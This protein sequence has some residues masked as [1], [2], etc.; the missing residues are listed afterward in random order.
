MTWL[1]FSKGLETTT[2]SGVTTTT[3]YNYSYEMECPVTVSLTVCCDMLWQWH[4]CL[5]GSNDFQQHG[6]APALHRFGWID[7]PG[8]EGKRLFN[9]IPTYNEIWIWNIAE[10]IW[11]ELIFHT[12]LG[13]SSLFHV[14]PTKVVC[15]MGWV[16][17]IPW[18]FLL[19]RFMCHIMSYSLTT[20]KRSEKS[21]GKTSVEEWK[22]L[23]NQRIF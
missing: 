1:I 17:A 2:R 3:C 21:I 15:C 6:F 12:S 7:L 23:Q 22:H 20:T 13:Q 5:P 14:I 8:R 19:D 18:R 16:S 9:L 10:L 11:C 4:S